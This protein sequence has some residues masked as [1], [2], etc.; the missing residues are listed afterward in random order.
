MLCVVYIAY[1][2]HIFDDKIFDINSLL[3]CHSH[4]SHFWKLAEVML[5]RILLAGLAL[6]A[7]VYFLKVPAPGISQLKKW[8]ELPEWQ[9]EINTNRYE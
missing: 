8:S 1:K 6:L 9:R 2:Q 4:G 3:V 7:A 5:L